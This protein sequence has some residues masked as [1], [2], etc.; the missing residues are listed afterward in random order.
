MSID[1]PKMYT[2]FFL[3]VCICLFLSEFFEYKQIHD[4]INLAIFPLLISYTV[5]KTN[6]IGKFFLC[7]L[8]CFGL[9]DICYRIGG[10]IANSYTISNALLVIGYIFLTIHIIS[11]LN[12]RQL[13]KRFF[14]NIVV[15]I[16]VGIYLFLELNYMV[17]LEGNHLANY[18]NISYNLVIITL[19]GLALLN[20]LYHDSLIT[21]K[22]LIACALLIFSEFVQTTYFFIGSQKLLSNAYTILLS[23][24]Y[25][26]FFIYIKD[27]ELRK[28]YLN[29]NYG[30]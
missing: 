27:F 8:F 2:L 15:L 11:D 4:Y 7:F 28:N 12:L 3:I 6:G 29:K 21:L 16:G 10:N 13:V 24:S 22:L 5:T 18:I 9:S 30:F 1:T 25:F 17:F 23:L 14:L 26:S 20:Y 19:L